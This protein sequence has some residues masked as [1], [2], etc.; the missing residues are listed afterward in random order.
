M[1]DVVGKPEAPGQAQQIAD[2]GH[3]VLGDD[4]LGHQIV[5]AGVH[6]FAQQLFVLPAGAQDLHEHGVEH[7]LLHAGLFGIEGQVLGGVHEV[8]A[9]HAVHAAAVQ[10]HVNG[11]DAGVL[12]LAGLFAADGLAGADE[13]LAG[14]GVGDVRIRHL[15][16]NAGG[17][18]Q[19]LVELVAAHAH[20]VI[21]LGVKEERVEQALGALA[22]GRLAGLLPLVDLDEALVAAVGVVAALEGGHEALVLAEQIDDLLIGAVAQRAQDQRDGQLARPVDAHPQNVVGVRLVLQP[23][24]AVGDDRGGKEMLAGLVDLIF[25]VYAG[26]AHQLAHDDALRAVDDKGAMLGHEGEVAHEYVGFLDFAGLAVFEADE[27]LQRGGIGHVALLAAL[28]AVFGLVQRIVHKLQREVLGVVHDGT[29]V[30]EHLAHVHFQKAAVGVFLHFNEIGHVQDLVD[31]R[32]ALPLPQLPHLNL[33]HHK[34]HH[35]LCSSHVY[36]LRKPRPFPLFP[37]KKFP[38][39]FLRR[40][41]YNTQQRTGAASH[42]ND[43]DAS[44]NYSA[45]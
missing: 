12:D 31:V 11:V 5:R 44:L 42:S 26:G 27:H 25:V 7:V 6:G 30:V 1:V 34:C 39:A 9:H 28:H 35:P 2:G 32:E 19:L 22:G 15:A 17:Q 10:A 16:L 24:A 29:D 45:F 23:R 3:D 36:P 41:M 43:T 38:V 18:G 13:H 33:M 40:G 14:G 21:A 8:V 37:V 4:V 20:E